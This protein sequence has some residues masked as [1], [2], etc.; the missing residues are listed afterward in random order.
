[1]QNVEIYRMNFLDHG[2]KGM[3]YLSMLKVLAAWFIFLMILYGFSIFRVHYIQNNI[4]EAKS[5]IQALN[6]KKEGSLK[7]IQQASRKRVGSSAKQGYSSIVQ[8]RPFWSKV[9]SEITGNLPPQV[10]LDSINVVKE[11]QAGERLEIK[12]R[13]KSQRALTN[14]IMKIES[15]PIFSGTSIVHTK[16]S[17]KSSSVL[18][19][20]IITRPQASG[21]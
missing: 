11:E 4:I 5:G 21:I 9:I 14:F 3:T 18:V 10:W 1:M 8:N 2:R 15:S 16:L 19:Y 13:A 17:D 6:A 7:Q 20:E 12:G